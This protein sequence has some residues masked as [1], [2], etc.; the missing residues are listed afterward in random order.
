MTRAEG[1]QVGRALPAFLQTGRRSGGAGRG[2]SAQ[3][4]SGDPSVCVFVWSGTHSVGNRAHSSRPF[5]PRLH[6]QVQ[7]AESPAS[8]SYCSQIFISA[9]FVPGRPAADPPPPSPRA[10]THTHTRTVRIRDGTRRHDPSSQQESLDAARR[11]SR[12]AKAPNNCV[13]PAETRRCIGHPGRRC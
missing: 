1:A 8:S 3:S 12:S 6:R 4:G 9:L 2:T 13:Q 10:H 7:P 5:F 11:G